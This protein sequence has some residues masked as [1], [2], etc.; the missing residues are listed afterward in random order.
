MADKKEKSNGRH[1]ALT[2]VGAVLCVILIPILVINVTLI[3]KSY[4]NSDEVPKFGG[5]C[6]LI[7][8]TG[9]MEPEIKSGDLIVCKQIDGEQV[10][11]DDVIAFFDPASNNNSVLTHRVVEIVTEDGSLSFKTK[12]DANNAA[13]SD[14]VPADNLVG[15][16]QF[17][18]TGAG[19]VAMF[20]QTPA[21]LVVCV[22]VPLVLLI[23]YDVLRRRRYEKKNQEDTDALLKELEE[24]KAQKAIEEQN[25]ETK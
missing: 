9:S 4:T 19:N 16:Y 25:E 14:L 17:K 12:G 8:L 11:V 21:G 13:D 18:I 20:M 15:I 2:V 10:K 5:Y 7:V 3:I 22:V 6:P 1:I 24:L 23:G